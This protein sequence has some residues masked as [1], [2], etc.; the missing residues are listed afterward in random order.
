VKDYKAGDV[1]TAEVEF[2]WHH[3]TTM[4]DYSLLVYS[5]QDIQIKDKDEKTN[6][7]HFDGSEPSGYT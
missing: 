7:P 3:R 5:K 6:M 4:R 2:D 1:I